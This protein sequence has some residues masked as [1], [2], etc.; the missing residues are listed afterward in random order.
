[1]FAKRPADVVLIG[2]EENALTPEAKAKDLPRRCGESK[3][4]SAIPAKAGI[5]L[6]HSHYLRHQDGFPLSRE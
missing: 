2:G 4:K 5:H 1:L 3:Q 6:I